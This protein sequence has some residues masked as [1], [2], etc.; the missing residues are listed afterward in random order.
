MTDAKLQFQVS[1]D[2]NTNPFLYLACYDKKGNYYSSNFYNA[3]TQSRGSSANLTVNNKCRIIGVYVDYGKSPY[4]Y[5]SITPMY[6]SDISTLLPGIINIS[7]VPMMGD[8][9]TSYNL[10][11]LTVHNLALGLTKDI[12]GFVTPI[13][14]NADD[15]TKSDQ[16]D[17]CT[18]AG[19]VI[20][21]D[22][23]VTTITRTN[24]AYYYRHNI[25]VSNSVVSMYKSTY[26]PPSYGWVIILIVLLVLVILGVGGFVLYKHHHRIR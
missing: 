11:S 10:S 23:A 25:C 12:S 21:G 26:I 15:A 2:T 19:D 17:A 1:N 24:G 14:G 8:I 16:A 7:T 18:T 6:V 4:T 22:A 3:S 20:I 13:T 9:T 5:Y